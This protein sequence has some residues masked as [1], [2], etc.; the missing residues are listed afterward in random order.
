[1]TLLLIFFNFQ[2][3]W[4][5]QVEETYPLPFLAMFSIHAYSINIEPHIGHPRPWRILAQK[6][7]YPK[8]P[9]GLFFVLYY[10]ACPI[11]LLSPLPLFGVF[12]SYAG[13]WRFKVSAIHLQSW[14]V[15]KVSKCMVVICTPEKLSDFEEGVRGS[16]NKVGGK[17]CSSCLQTN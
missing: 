16:L 17:Y 5:C 4:Q 12:I 2:Y 7:I 11:L 8:H 6:F 14:M 13:H 9:M 1:M 3:V 15:L 10:L